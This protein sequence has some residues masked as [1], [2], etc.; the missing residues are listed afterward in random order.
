[1]GLPVTLPPLRERLDDVP[2]LARFF[3]QKY[4]A[5]AQREVE[6]LHPDTIRT[7]QQY[8]WP[9]NVRELA[10]A[11][12]WAVVFGKS[13]RIRPDD[14]PAEVMRGG[15]RSLSAV[16]PLEDALQSHEKKLII[17]ALEET[18]GNVVEA[19]VLLARAPNYL[20]RRIS[21]LN[22]RPEL[23]RIRQRGGEDQS[24]FGVM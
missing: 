4:K 15:N 23:D 9:G 21:Q 13:N 10:R 18:K 12:Y 24:S 2:P 6:S 8:S 20:Q 3:F 11:V 17:R 1:M 14:L 22:L 19:S 16:G 7:L 5:T